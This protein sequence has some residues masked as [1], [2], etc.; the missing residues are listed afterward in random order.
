MYD[1]LWRSLHLI[2]KEH[3]ESLPER[4]SLTAWQRASSNFDGVALTGELRYAEQPGGPIFQ[5]SLNA[6]K[7]QKSYRLARKFGG[8]RF[9]V[10]GMPGLSSENLP[11]HLKKNHSA[12]RKSIIKRLVDTDF[13]FLG[14][15]W[16][17]FYL[18]PD[19]G[20]NRQKK[21]RTFSGI[22]FRIYFF[23]RDG[24]DFRNPPLTGEI[25][26]RGNVHAPMSIEKLIDWFMPATNNS[27]QTCLKFFARLALGVSN[28]TPTVV[29]RPEEIVRT[30]DARAD[31]PEVRRVN[32][33]REDAKVPKASNSKAAVMNDVSSVG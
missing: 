28:T 18:K 25:D 6:M 24:H 4:S 1:E 14:R 31:N 7:V 20:N 9:C 15:I 8:D 29:F 33:G 3:K 22:K 16:R 30:R 5:F 2:V 21:Q 12:I 17:A 13:C 26:P 19:G 23:A 32:H 11:T 27:G 10:I